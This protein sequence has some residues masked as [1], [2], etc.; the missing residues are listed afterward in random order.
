MRDQE[1]EAED[2]SSETESDLG[3]W[4]ASTLVDAAETGIVPVLPWR[5]R[6]VIQKESFLKYWGE[7]WSLRHFIWA[8][9]RA[10]AL[11]TTRGAVLGKVWL[12][13]SPFLNAMIFYVVFGLL[14]KISRGIPNF[15]GYLVIGV[16]FFPVY[17]AAL[18]SG[19]K[20]L[21]SSAKMVKAFPFPK[22]TVVMAWSVRAVL[23]FLPVLLAA[24]LFVVFIPPHVVPTHLWPLVIPILVLGFVF[25]NGMALLLSSVT[26]A[27]P[28]LKFVWPLL[29]RFWFYTSCVFFS[30]SRFE[31]IFAVV[32]IMQAN[33]AYVFL[34]MCRDVLIYN[35]A[36]SLFQWVYLAV[37]SLGMWVVGAVVFWWREDSYVEELG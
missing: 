4:V 37:W 27:L 19:S 10:K 34:T 23:D 13:L 7:V 21:I 16:L 12:V 17:S 24:L 28:D 8:D 2:L 36:P 1:T 11:Q 18:S 25:G 22:A 9:A 30:I 31:S 5:L 3:D 14:L 35:T 29:G 20:A 26:A 32:V 33:P 6:P 15:L